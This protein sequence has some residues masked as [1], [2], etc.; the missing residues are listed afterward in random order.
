MRL[1]RKFPID[2]LQQPVIYIRLYESKLI[3]IDAYENNLK[4]VILE[5]QLTVEGKKSFT[6]GCFYLT[7]LSVRLLRPKKKNLKPLS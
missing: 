3:K 4:E 6:F 5:S 7:P 1:A 2:C